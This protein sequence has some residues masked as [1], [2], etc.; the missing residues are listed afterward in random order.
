MENFPE[1][2]EDEII[3]RKFPQECK[4]ASFMTDGWNSTMRKKVQYII[5]ALSNTKEDEWFVHADCDIVLFPEWKQVLIQYE[6]SNLDMMIQ[7][8]YASLCAGFFFCKNNSKTR[9]L[10][11]NVIKTLNQFEHDQYA[12]NHWIKH[13][14]DVKVGIL[15]DS[16]FT[17]GLFGKGTWDGQDFKVPN[18]SDLKMFHGNWTVG[19][20]RKIEIIKKVIE[21]KTQTI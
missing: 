15:P 8:D 1:S 11:D 5:D 3:V 7:N 17:Y 18:I 2:E 12:M 16:Y 19:V 21:Q 4:D 14:P 9:T 10:W 6:K 20:N 13:T